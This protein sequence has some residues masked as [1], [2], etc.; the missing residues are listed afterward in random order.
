MNKSDKSILSLICRICLGDE[1]TTDNPLIT[2]C[3]CAG[4]MKFIHVD[5]LS[6]WLK[7]KRTFK[8]ND[9]VETYCWKYLECELC[10]VRFPDRI[11]SDEGKFIELTPFDRPER[12]YLVLESV[13]Q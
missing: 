8:A 12:D 10:K 4:T 7:N 9:F 2:P 13:T 3:K 5:C 1:N 11:I 6:E